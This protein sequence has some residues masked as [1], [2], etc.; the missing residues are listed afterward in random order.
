MREGAKAGR[1]VEQRHTAPNDEAA[2]FGRSR[3]LPPGKI[4]LRPTF[5]TRFAERIKA[6]DAMRASASWRIAAA[7]LSAGDAMGW[8][9]HRSFAWLFFRPG[10]RPRRAVRRRAVAT[11][12]Y[13]LAEPRLALPARRLLR[14]FP[15]IQRRVRVMLLAPATSHRAPF[16]NVQGPS[17]LSLRAR[18]VY[19]KLKAAVAKHDVS[20]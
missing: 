13:V 4:R 19:A 9:V 8:F 7:L 20:R 11:A 1:C 2:E 12:R 6:L 10:S 5:S 3:C 18:D 17:D 14:L 16:Y 15:A